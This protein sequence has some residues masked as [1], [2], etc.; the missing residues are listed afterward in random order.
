MVLNEKGILKEFDLVVYNQDIVAV[1]GGMEDTV[2]RYYKPTDEKFNWIAA[3]DEG[4]PMATYDVINKKT[5]VICYMIWCSNPELFRGSYLCHETG[6][7]TLELF[8]YIGAHV[9]YDDQ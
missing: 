2:N 7:A 6:H 8:K 1:I 9:D 5:G 3:P 4:H